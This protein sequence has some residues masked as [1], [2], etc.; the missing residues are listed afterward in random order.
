LASQ[1]SEFYKQ[2]AAIHDAIRTAARREK[3]RETLDLVLITQLVRELHPDIGL[4][5]TELAK[6]IIRAAQAAGVQLRG[7]TES[8]GAGIST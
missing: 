3:L 5:P 8:E 1:F 7:Q 4:A 2:S 6:A